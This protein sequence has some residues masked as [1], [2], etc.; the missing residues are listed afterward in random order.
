MPFQTEQEVAWAGTFGSDYMERNREPSGLASK[1]HLFSCILARTQGIRSVFEAGANIGLSL[2]AMRTL[3]PACELHG[4]E[5][6][7]TAWQELRTQIGDNA[8][9]G[10]ILDFESAE[11]F[12]LVFTSGLLIHIDPD[13]LPQAYDRLHALTGRYLLLN[14]YFNPSPV[15]VTY[16]GIARRLFKRDF[17]GEMLD[18][19]GDLELVD[20]GFSYRRDPV[21]PQDDST[22]FL[23][24]RR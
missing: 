6:N 4:V 7:E 18:R 2:A 20:Y 15:E 17:C 12:D 19:F 13:H 16:R 1:I 3:L 5:I 9:L 14:E 21:F 23:L 11:R 8:R 10:S 24:R 22:W